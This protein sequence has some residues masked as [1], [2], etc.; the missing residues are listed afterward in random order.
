MASPLV[1]ACQLVLK[2][3]LHD[4]D[5]IRD[6]FGGPERSRGSAQPDAI[7]VRLAV[8]SA[9]AAVAYGTVA[10]HAEVSPD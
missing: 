2:I 3:L 4:A 8:S 10:L 7:L 9:A 5:V 1:K 6:S